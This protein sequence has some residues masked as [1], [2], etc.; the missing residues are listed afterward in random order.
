MESKF[1][2]CQ[3]MLLLE[4]NQNIV[5]S[6]IQDNTNEQTFK[7]AYKSDNQT[8]DNYNAK[9]LRQVDAVD[10]KI[11]DLG[12]LLQDLQERCLFVGRENSVL[13]PLQDIL[14]YL[15]ACFEKVNNEACRIGALT[16]K[17]KVPEPKSFIGTSDVLG[18]I[19]IHYE[20]VSK[21]FRQIIAFIKKYTNTSYCVGLYLNMNR[22]IK[23]EMDLNECI[24]EV[25]QLLKLVNFLK[26]Q[27][28]AYTVYTGL[29]WLKKAK[30]NIH[31]KAR[32]DVLFDE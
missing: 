5:N 10:K 18:L 24:K 11:N 29:K 14:Q 26:F 4:E 22:V 28:A 20:I 30:I 21:I 2:Y 1:E 25:K 17:F 31:Y 8:D 15:T 27:N 23:A 16:K 12:V 19:K 9:L 32:R 6:N 7:E 13:P 3:N